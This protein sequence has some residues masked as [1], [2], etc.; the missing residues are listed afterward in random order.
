MAANNPINYEQVKG[1][2]GSDIKLLFRDNSRPG[3][4]FSIMEMILFQTGHIFN[5]EI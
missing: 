1:K 4:S 2:L 5:M 3:Q